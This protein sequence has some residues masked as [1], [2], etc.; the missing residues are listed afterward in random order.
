MNMLNKYSSA[1][2]T[3]KIMFSRTVGTAHPFLDPTIVGIAVLH[4]AKPVNDTNPGCQTN[5]AMRNI[6]FPCGCT[7]CLAAV[8]ERKL[9]EE[10]LSESYKMLEKLSTHLEVVRED[11]Q[12]RIA[13]ELHDEM[14]GVL[15]ALNI[16]VGMLAT[17]IPAEM[18]HLL[19][20][21]TTMEKLVTSGIQAMRHIVA[22]LRPCM[23]DE[24]GLFRALE[25]YVED[26]Q[27][28]TGI[29]CNLRLP[30]EDS[31]IQGNRATAI[32]RI[33]QES[34]TNVAKHAQANKVIIVLSDWGESLVLTVKD[35]GKGFDPDNRKTN[36]FGLMGIRER[37]SL[38]GGKAI[39][40][41]AA[42]K[43]TTVRINLPG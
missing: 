22:E 20:E 12:K 32:F 13:R 6:H 34:L 27:K 4:L 18:T 9:A 29:E 7:Q 28:N 26:F 5:V 14:G 15:T 21:V 39:I 3:D 25:H 33:V 1:K 38:F 31:A 2:V 35:N 40:S 37:A 30:E 10:K 17:Q 42:G 23:L 41:S 11:E 16:Y 8:T 24:V 36:S 19:A 43:G